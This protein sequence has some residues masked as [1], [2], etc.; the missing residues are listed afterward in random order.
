[1]TMI[2]MGVNAGDELD[3]DSIVVTL[4]CG[5]IDAVCISVRCGFMVDVCLDYALKDNL[6][7]ACCCSVC[8]L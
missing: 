3:D 8:K 4:A 2:W 7:L 6:T 1:M 5:R